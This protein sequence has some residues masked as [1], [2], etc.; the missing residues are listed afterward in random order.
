VTARWVVD[1]AEARDLELVWEPISLL[2]KNNTSPE[3][4]HHP[5]VEWT[6]KLLRVMESVRK[7]E[8]DRAVYPLYIEYG[9]RIHHDRERMWDAAE[10]LTAVGLDAR[11]AAA[12]DNPAWDDVVR[13]R[14]DEGLALVGNDVGTPLIA[15]GAADGRTV[16]NFG[17]VI[18][19]VPPG[20]DKLRLWDAFTTLTE[21]DGFWEL[22]RTR[23]QKPDFGERP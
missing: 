23:T 8:G 14:M 11:H 2:M 15:Y 3:S 13:S 9:R 6:T 16:A 19:R 12:A 10:A 1:I 7:A 21:M 18:T 5:A 17:P 22:K 20:E 4:E